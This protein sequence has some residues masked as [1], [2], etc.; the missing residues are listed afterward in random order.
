[1][2]VLRK[3][4]VKS[5]VLRYNFSANVFM[6]KGDFMRNLLFLALCLT[7]FSLIGCGGPGNDTIIGPYPITTVTAVQPT[8]SLPKV[9]VGASIRAALNTAGAQL[10]LV[11]KDG[12]RLAMTANDL[13]TSVSFSTSTAISA[14]NLLSNGSSYVLN[15]SAV[16]NGVTIP[17]QVL[18][19]SGLAPGMTASNTAD[20][21][22]V[23]TLK[24][25]TAS[26]K[27]TYTYQITYTPSGSTQAV[28]SGTLNPPTG[29]IPTP[30]PG[31]Y[32]EKVVY[33]GTSGETILGSFETT[34]V[35]TTQSVFRIYLNAAVT[36][37]P[38]T[39]SATLKG[40][41]RTLTF[42]EGTSQT[43]LS[44]DP[45]TQKILNLTIFGQAGTE[46]LASATSYELSFTSSIMTAGGS[47]ASLALSSTSV[48]KVKTEGAGSNVALAIERIMLAS[49]TSEILL[50][51]AETSNVSF[52]NMTLKI[53][54]TDAI[55]GVPAT[56]SVGDN[57]VVSFVNGRH[58]T[59]TLNAD[60][61][62]MTMTVNTAG[63]FAPLSG[64]NLFLNSSR[65]TALSSAQT[66]SLQNG[67]PYRVIT[68]KTSLQSWDAQKWNSV[69]NLWES[70]KTG[71]TVAATA[72]RVVLTFDY[73][74]PA[75]DFSSSLLKKGKN[76]SEMMSVPYGTFFDAPTA[77]GTSLIHPFKAGK[78]LTAGTYSIGFGGGVIPLD[79][80]NKP[81]DTNATITFTVP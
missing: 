53:Y 48:Y 20:V 52:Q 66:T 76:G 71:T 10:F 12:T 21:G 40:V 51:T 43:S 39:F 17:L 1:M 30:L 64:Y 63:Q 77:S 57:T 33:V 67:V 59:A 23:I 62:S 61:R 46:K 75:G 26:G 36:A 60:A 25:D 55:A 47:V 7:V 3:G 38:T 45:S 37:I 35:S 34:G 32:V 74:V 4:I 78:V 54:F 28:T 16:I 56:Y 70:V 5:L 9:T 8:I 24:N 72:G 73:T 79:A 80:M 50:S 14:A 69:T 29:T 49:G 2:T 27:V 65:I 11:L 22:A 44:L 13:T 19:P 58:A 18:L 81:V 68:K 6:T 31:L 41:G 15:I 42:A